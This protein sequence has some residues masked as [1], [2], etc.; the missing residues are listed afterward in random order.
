MVPAHLADGLCLASLCLHL[1][2]R[3][4]TNATLDIIS[5]CAF[6]HEINA[7]A[8]QGEQQPYAQAVNEQ[9]ESIFAR[10]LQPWYVQSRVVSSAAPVPHL[11][12]EG[13]RCTAW[14][15]QCVC[16]LR[17]LAHAAP[18]TSPTGSTSTAPPPAVARLVR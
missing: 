4:V 1:R 2:Y 10:V 15:S 9:T 8:L 3:Y 11:R 13:S 7:Q 14:H 16:G 17:A 5:K 12:A 6:G 18:G